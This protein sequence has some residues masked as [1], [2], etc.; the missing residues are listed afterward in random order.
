[1][2][3]VQEL[4]RPAIDN[5][6]AGA[7]TR[8][9]NLMPHPI[10]MMIL[11]IATAVVLTWLVPSG[12]FDRAPNKH[13]LAGTY[14]VIPKEYSLAAL[15]WPHHS[16]PNAAF[17]ADIGSLVRSI[18]AGMIQAS[19]LIFMIMFLGGMFGVLRASG[20]LDAGMERLLAATGAT[21]TCWRQ[22]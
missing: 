19:G 14:R 11:I 12:L 15:L 6:D 3:S 22:C 7:A 16:T 18:P 13:V 5:A 8:R 21:S 2:S 4:L 1:M 10:V 17:P 20:A 9:R